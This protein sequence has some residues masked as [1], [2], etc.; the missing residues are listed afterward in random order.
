MA[1]ILDSLVGSCTKKLQKIITEEVVRILG[2]KEDLKELQKTM[3]RI[4]CFL[5]DAEKRWMEESA[6]NNW[7]GELRDAMYSADEIID[8]ARSEGGK[9]LAERHSSSR[10]STKCGGISLF[11]CIPSLQKRHK[12]AIKIR[13]FNA[14]LENISEQGER[15]LKLQHMHP[16]AEVPTVKHMR[17]S[18][19]V[20]PN[21]V[22]KETLH[23]CKRLV[24][25][26]L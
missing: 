1:S 6:V 22:G 25:M 8:L 15:F 17:T 9:L 2:V 12:I 26:V 21:L 7:L 4:Q 24:E 23:A 5:N 18:P 14:E 20:E 10:N 11:T 3:S 13:D 19:L 16:T